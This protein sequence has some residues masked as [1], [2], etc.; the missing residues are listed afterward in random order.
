MEGQD[1]PLLYQHSHAGAKE[2]NVNIDISGIRYCIDE[3]CIAI[4]DDE[5]SGVG[6]MQVECAFGSVPIIFVFK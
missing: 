6:N 2:V 1:I 3:D 4:C 5:I